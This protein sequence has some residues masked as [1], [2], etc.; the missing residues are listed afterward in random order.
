ME[1]FSLLSFEVYLSWAKKKAALLLP[2]FPAILI[3]TW[4]GAPTALRVAWLLFLLAAVSV[5]VAF[6]E[7]RRRRLAYRSGDSTRALEASKAEGATREIQGPLSALAVASVGDTHFARRLLLSQPRHNS[8]E[9]RELELCAKIMVEA[10]DGDH[11]L[12]LRLCEELEEIPARSSSRPAR[13]LARRLGTLA[14]A[15]ASAGCAKVSD[16]EILRDTAVVEPM[17]YWVCRY[18]AALHCL[19]R[20]APDVALRLVER[21]PNWPASSAFRAFAIRLSI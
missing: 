12:S 9:A 8:E 17:M 11:A 4:F 20:N 16:L 6:R 7:A 21:A 19:Q 5:G 13:S 14:V 18:T 3:A 2:L 10:L 1:A 15:R